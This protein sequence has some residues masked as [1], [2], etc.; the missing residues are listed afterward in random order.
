M[1]GV[2][3][4]RGEADFLLS[5]SHPLAKAELGPGHPGVP[6]SPCE[7]KSGFREVFFCQLPWSYVMA[8]GL[9]PSPGRV[10][11]DLG[12]SRSGPHGGAGWELSWPDCGP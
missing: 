5:H 11:R 2:E 12:L 4:Q 9:L 3:A 10:S 8:L 7:G 1:H 6:S